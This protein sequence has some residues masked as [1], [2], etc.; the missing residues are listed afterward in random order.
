MINLFKHKPF[1]ELL[2]SCQLDQQALVQLAG[3]L[4]YQPLEIELNR[5]K[6]KV[7]E[8]YNEVAGVENGI[9]KH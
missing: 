3:K 4:K 8:I 6:S 1:L 9:G 7:E 2:A 5:H